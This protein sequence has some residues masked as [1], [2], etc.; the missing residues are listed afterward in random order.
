ME[1]ADTH[2]PSPRQEQGV[3]RYFAIH[4]LEALAS[5]GNA[6]A[7]ESL[8]RLIATGA[9]EVRKR[10]VLSYIESS[11][12]VH[13]AQASAANLLPPEEKVYAYRRTVPAQD[14]PLQTPPPLN[15]NDANTLAR[16]QANV[17]KKK[18]RPGSADE[19]ADAAGAERP[20]Q[21]PQTEGE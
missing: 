12:N 20:L 18:F 6:E 15:P 14:M 2:G 3:E 10:A 5:R 13:K 11:S 9:P 4:H 8:E 1:E 21:G 7:K 17:G 16:A 19:A